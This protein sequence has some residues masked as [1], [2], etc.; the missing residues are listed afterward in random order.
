MLLAI[1]KP[2]LNET[3][4]EANLVTLNETFL[5]P[6]INELIASKV[7]EK[8]KPD[9]DWKYHAEKL[10]ELEAKIEAAFETTTLPEKPNRDPVNKFLI[11]LRLNRG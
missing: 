2:N 1:S 6:G 9:L 8:A 3:K 10:D 4:V 11:E 7:A 5:I